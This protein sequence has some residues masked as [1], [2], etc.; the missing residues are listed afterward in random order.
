MT[1]FIRTATL[2]SLLLATT[3]SFA[4]TT[5]YELRDLHSHN[6]WINYPGLDF[7]NATSAVLTI[8]KTTPEME[9]QLKSLDVTFPN[10]AK[11]SAKDF[12][13]VNG[14]YR[15]IVSDAWIY[16]QIVVDVLIPDFNNINNNFIN[17]DVAISEKVGFIN[18]QNE[19]RGEHLLMIDGL[20]HDI[21]SSKIVDTASA[22]IN[23][24]R[25]NL[26]LKSRLSAPLP[27]A[28]GGE[29]GYAI[30]VLWMGRG[31]KTIYIHSGFP[32]NYYEFITP[33]GLI[34]EELT[35]PEGPMIS[36]TAKDPQGN[37]IPSP[38]F[39]L[40]ELLDQAYGPQF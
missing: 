3:S 20:T 14:V 13:R 26:S 12:K 40:K 19:E 34:L 39:R 7:S 21:T 5:K 6:G 18:P 10:A 22:I 8:E 9:P 33:V 2:V 4:I 36:V 17:I 15:A 32:Q 24:K 30:D 37:L 28:G 11:L 23:G 38:P 35:A 25:A 1:L 27:E 16:R 31:E 29:G